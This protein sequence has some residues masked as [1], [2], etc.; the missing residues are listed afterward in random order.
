MTVK[1]S[2]CQHKNP[3]DTFYCGRCGA[4][5]QANEDISITHTKTL[6]ILTPSKTIA[7]KY[8]IQAELGRGGMGV[9]YKARD[10]RL[11][12][13]VAL[14]FLPAESTRDIEAKKRFVQ[15]GQAAA[16]LEHP[17]ICTVYEVDEAVE[18]LHKTIEMAPQFFYSHVILGLVYLAQSKMEEA[19]SKFEKAYKLSGGTPSVV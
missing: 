4:R 14:K 8:N 17:N 6:K 12:R 15:E 11:K 1:C 7:G 16:A 19:I 18:G 9:V 5:L 13:M 2:K 3:D 10:T